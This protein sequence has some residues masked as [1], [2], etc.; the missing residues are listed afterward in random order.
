M[1]ESGDDVLQSSGLSKASL[2]FRAFKVACSS[3][4][5]EALSVCV[6]WCGIET[7]GRCIF[8]KFG[9]SM[10]F[11]SFLVSATDVASIAKASFDGGRN[12][13]PE[14]MSVSANGSFSKAVV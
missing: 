4:D 9:S 2:R 3:R 8:D 6:L 7:G 5:F 11:E 14:G 1:F 12:E 10:T 13:F